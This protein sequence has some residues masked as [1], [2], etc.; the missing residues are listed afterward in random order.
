MVPRERPT[1][2]ARAPATKVACGYGRARGVIPKHGG[3]GI[4]DAPDCLPA[5]HGEANRYAQVLLAALDHPGWSARQ[6]I[7]LRAQY[8]KWILRAEGR[9]PQFEEFG[10]FPRFQG[11]PPPTATD[12]VIARWRKRNPRTPAERKRREIPTHKYLAIRRRDR[13]PGPS[14]DDD[15]DDR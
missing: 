1:N 10:T 9:D 11:T 4:P 15:G 13:Q 3:P 2:C 14:T 12:L 7:R 6:R 5:A 8:R